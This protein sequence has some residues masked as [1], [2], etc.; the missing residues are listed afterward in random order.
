[1]CAWSVAAVDIHDDAAFH[2]WWDALRRAIGHARDYSTYWSLREAQGAL[3]AGGNSFDQHAF[4]VM[5]D[6][7]TVAAA[8]VTLPKLDNLHVAY[9]SV[10]VVP[11]HRRR[12][13][14]AAL[15]DQVQR[16][17]GEHGR[18]TMQAEVDV[19]IDTDHSPGSAFLT[20]HGFTVGIS[21]LHRVLDLPVSAD[22]LSD[23]AHAAVAHH[24]AYTLVPWEDVTPDRYMAGFCA[25]QE[26]FNEEAPS[27]DLDVERE[28]WD[29]ERVRSRERRS[30]AQGRH[31]QCT[32]AVMADGAVVALTEMVTSEGTPERALQ[33]GTLVMPGH[34]GHRLGLATKVAN[35]QHFQRRFPDVQAVHSWNAAENTHMVAINDAL[36]FRPVEQL[37]EMQRRL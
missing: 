13:L 35:L 11:E 25:L 16:L 18:H 21:D 2:A 27:G 22:R 28:V 15:L 5:V 6:G 20:A 9:V 12:G 17:C 1:M 30:Q 8:A 23:L 34:R 19:P 37:I 4:A 26:A 24:T 3:R 7:E 10:G 32:A 33:G 31:Q 14:G 29:E 36:G